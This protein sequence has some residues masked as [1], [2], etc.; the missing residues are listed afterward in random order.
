MGEDS[1]EDSAEDSCEDSGG[2][3]EAEEDDDDSG[4]EV[5]EDGSQRDVESIEPFNVLLEDGNTR[6]PG[7]DMDSE[8][9]KAA[10]IESATKA[11][12]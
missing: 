3:G 9:V 7:V 5:D 10:F 12:C 6:L 11:G 8:L 2:L 1:A 4:D